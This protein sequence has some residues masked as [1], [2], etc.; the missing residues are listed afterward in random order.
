MKE[1]SAVIWLEEVIRKKS[2]LKGIV[3]RLGVRVRE[4]FAENH[5]ARFF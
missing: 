4:N 2:V 3:I 1:K 5:L